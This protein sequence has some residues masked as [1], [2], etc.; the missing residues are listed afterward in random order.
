MNWTSMHGVAATQTG[1]PTLWDRRRQMDLGSMICVVMFRSGS[2]TIMK[3]NITGPV[4]K[5]T[6]REQQGVNIAHR[7]V[8]LCSIRHG[9]SAPPSVT[10]LRRMTLAGNSDFAWRRFRGSLILNMI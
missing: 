1:R 7:V 3:L 2:V 9:A 8:V 6:Q 4:P 5:I 10:D